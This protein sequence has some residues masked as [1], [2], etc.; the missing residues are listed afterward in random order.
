M[1][2]YTFSGSS[3]DVFQYE[4]QGCGGDEAYAYDDEIAAFKI[5]NDHGGLI[6][7]GSYSPKATGNGCWAVGVAPLAEDVPLPDWPMAISLAK[8]GY[9]TELMID[10]PDGV[11]ITP[12]RH[13]KD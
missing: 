13:E 4:E 12:S 5:T 11:R 1:P 8:N 10:A 3:D 7:I 6:V 2:I 9:S